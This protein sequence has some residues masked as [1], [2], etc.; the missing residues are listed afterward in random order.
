MF[1]ESIKIKEIMIFLRILQNL[2]AHFKLYD[3]AELM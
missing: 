2:A 1:S 3:A